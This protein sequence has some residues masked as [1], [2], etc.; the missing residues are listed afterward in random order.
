MII[1]IVSDKVLGLINPS[2]D[3]HSLIMVEHLNNSDELSWFK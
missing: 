2:V 3:I 1:W